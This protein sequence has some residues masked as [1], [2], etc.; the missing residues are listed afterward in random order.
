MDIKAVVFSGPSLPPNEIHRVTDAEWR[1]PAAQGDLFR[2][3]E[4]GFGIIGLIDGYFGWVPSVWHKEILWA[5]T[6]RIH[7]IGAASMGALRAAELE[8]F[9]MVG[10]GRVF[11]AFRDG[12]LEDDDEVAVLHRGAD[13]HQYN[14]VTEAM[15]DIR[16][17]LERAVSVGVIDRS[18]AATLECIAKGLNYKNRTYFRIIEIAHKGGLNPLVIELISEWIHNG[19]RVSVKRTDAL[20][21]IDLLNEYLR[22]GLQRQTVSYEFEQTIAW[23]NALAGFLQP[24]QTGQTNHNDFKNKEVGS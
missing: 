19:G 24:D 14:Q 16:A 7:V 15:V 17:T 18:S 11:E 22:N 20:A 23:Q 1:P 21:L 12:L 9:G 6:H 13:S 10:V 5:L 2:A 8:A 3:A 4:E